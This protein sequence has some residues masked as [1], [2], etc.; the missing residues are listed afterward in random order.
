MCPFRVWWWIVVS[1]GQESLRKDEPGDTTRICIHEAAVYM[2]R[3]SCQ[4]DCCFLHGWRKT[5]STF[6]HDVGTWCNKAPQDWWE[7][8]EMVRAVTW[9]EET[10]STFECNSWAWHEKSTEN[11]SHHPILDPH[12]TNL[13]KLQGANYISDFLHRH[14]FQTFF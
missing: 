7:C 9:W 6:E 5:R 13:C 12:C 10:Y 4:T 11:G 14:F 1:S 2:G 3:S 8:E